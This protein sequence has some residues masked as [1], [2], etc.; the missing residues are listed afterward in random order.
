VAVLGGFATTPAEELEDKLKETKRKAEPPKPN[1]VEQVN[2]D[3]FNV[4]D[5]KAWMVQSIGQEERK[6]KSA[7]WP[8]EAV[9]VGDGE[10]C[11]MY[12]F[13]EDHTNRLQGSVDDNDQ[14]LL[15]LKKYKSKT[16]KETELRVVSVADRRLLHSKE[17][18]HIAV[19][20]VATELGFT[21]DQIDELIAKSFNKKYLLVGD[22]PA[23]KECQQMVDA[24]V[25]SKMKKSS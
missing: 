4:D 16:S 7:R 11:L 24:L 13:S 14:V 19:L 12:S 3:A 6:G 8:V 9:S 18:N 2:V 22:I 10:S 15:Q 21:A 1:P 20:R 23:G 25:W 5:V 17:Q